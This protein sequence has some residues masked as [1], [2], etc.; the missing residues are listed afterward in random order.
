MRVGMYP[1]L[2]GATVAA[3]GA[4][5]PAAGGGA[6]PSAPAEPQP[7]ERVFADVL[8][9]VGEEYLA[10]RDAMVSKG[11]E[12]V[13]FLNRAAGSG[14][15]KAKTFAE[16]LLWRIQSPEQ[17]QELRESYV[18]EALAA[19]RSPRPRGRP[20]WTQQRFPT[21][22]A[23]RHAVAY[24]AEL[25]LKDR[26]DATGESQH[27]RF[28]PEAP[29]RRH[30]LVWQA[31]RGAIAILVETKHPRVVRIL[32]AF[33]TGFLAS[34]TQRPVDYRVRPVLVH[35]CRELRRL[36]DEQTIKELREALDRERGRQMGE[37]LIRVITEIEARLAVEHQ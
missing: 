31:K 7:L 30:S 20:G 11:R 34:E 1:L 28:P 3:L 26:P 14:D 4:S 25:L 8:S 19:M 37:R 15:W 23:H 21:L 10:A 27:V 16:L 13:P 12:A 22:T 24:F 35:A 32:T 2:A 9:K 36:G 5:A 18:R 17:V 6:P 29:S 33:V